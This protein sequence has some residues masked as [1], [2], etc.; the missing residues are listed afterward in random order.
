MLAHVAMRLDR[1]RPVNSLAAL[2]HLST[3]RLVGAGSWSRRSATAPAGSGSSRPELAQTCG[4]QRQFRG[5]TQGVHEHE[6][7]GTGH[8]GD[9]DRDPPTP[10][11][12]Q[13]RDLAGD[14]VGRAGHQNRSGDATQERAE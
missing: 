1:T 5:A 7:G 3:G 4:E 12:Q 10:E 2:D 14:N 8:G 9:H 13:R 11:R 6:D